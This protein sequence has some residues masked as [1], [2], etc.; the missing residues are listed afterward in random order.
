VQMVQVQPYAKHRSCDCQ[1]QFVF[2]GKIDIDM[3][4]REGLLV[5]IYKNIINKYKNHGQ[6]IRKTWSTIVNKW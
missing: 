2:I 3:L 1:N 5:N 6:H 4:R